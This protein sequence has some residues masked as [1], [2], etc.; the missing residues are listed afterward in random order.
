[1]NYHRPNCI[2]PDVTQARHLPVPKRLIRSPSRNDTD[3]V[4]FDDVLNYRRITL[5]LRR[6]NDGVHPTKSKRAFGASNACRRRALLVAFHD[7]QKGDR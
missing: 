6:V 7:G 3:G 1:M 4:I 5:R 2:V